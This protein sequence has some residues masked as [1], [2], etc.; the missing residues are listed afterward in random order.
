L[1]SVSGNTVFII[2]SLVLASMVLV[3]TLKLSNQGVVEEEM[4]KYRTEELAMTI[5]MVADFQNSGF[6]ELNLPQNFTVTLRENMPGPPVDSDAYPSMLT[7]N[8]NNKTYTA[9]VGVELQNYGEF[10]DSNICIR[11]NYSNSD[12]TRLSMSNEEFIRN[13]IIENIRSA[14][15]TS[16]IKN[17]PSNGKY[18]YSL[19]GVDRV[20]IKRYNTIGSNYFNVELD[21]GSNTKKYWLDS[22]GYLADWRC[23][24]D[25]SSGMYQFNTS[26]AHAGT[27]NWIDVDPDKVTRWR[28]MEEEDNKWVNVQIEQIDPDS[29]P[30]DKLVE[31]M[32]GEC[33]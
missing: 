17:Y 10:T 21:Y 31:V 24:G 9:G 2:V 16:G 19:N 33:R 6:F 32:P 8:F 5:E 23:G 25:P 4:L 1:S 3:N 11:Q 30:G 22:N 29:I 28:V 27:N 13:Y 18:S 14:C 12:V 20:R 26:S 7:L 15:T